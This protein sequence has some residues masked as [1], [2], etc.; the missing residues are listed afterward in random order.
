MERGRHSR[1]P[2]QLA[3]RFWSSLTR[4]SRR[5]LAL[6]TA[7]RALKLSSHL[8]ASN[9]PVL[10]LPFVSYRRKDLRACV[11]FHFASSTVTKSYG[12]SLSSGCAGIDSPSRIRL[13]IN[14]RCGLRTPTLSCSYLFNHGSR[15]IWISAHNLCSTRVN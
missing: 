13:S 3:T 9:S 14:T 5:D 2:L 6:S 12:S 10:R 7:P 4:A 11:R 8:I 1:S 15:C